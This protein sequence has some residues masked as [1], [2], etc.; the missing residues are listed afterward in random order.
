MAL[1]MILCLETNKRSNTD[2]IYISDT[3]NHFYNKGN[4]IKI[5][6]I[7]MNTKTKYNAKDVC[8]Q[9]KEKRDSYVHGE[10]RVIYCVD[11]DDYEINTEHSMALDNI[12]QY[13][14]QNGY[15]LVW[16]CHDVEEVYWGHRVVD[17]VKVKE[18]AKFRSTKKIVDQD[19]INLTQK[20]KR[21]NASNIMLV[22]DKYLDR[23]IPIS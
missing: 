11:T 23:K 1:Q 22:L 2:G 10:T 8:K 6:W 21:K 3:I 13:C 4:D 17:D 14:I 16:F 19:I 9:V 20:I 7:Y 18:A 15:D 5:S 12:E